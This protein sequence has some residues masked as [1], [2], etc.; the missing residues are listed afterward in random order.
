M[1]QTKEAPETGA[2]DFPHGLREAVFRVVT[3]PTISGGGRA[4][5]ALS[6][7][8]QAADRSEP[9]DKHRQGAR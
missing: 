9:A 7:P 6:A 2:S 3:M 8:K 5:L 4:C 1:S